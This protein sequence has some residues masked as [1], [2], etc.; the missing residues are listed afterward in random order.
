MLKLVNFAEEFQDWLASNYDVTTL[1]V[2]EN[3][4]LGNILNVYELDKYRQNKIFLTMF[5]EGGSIISSGRRTRQERT[6]RFVFRGNHGQEAI[7]H[8][9]E[10]VAWFKRKKTFETATYR[11]WLNRF[12]RLPTVISAEQSGVSLADLVLTLNVWTRLE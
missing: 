5:E 10:F 12:D 4:T 1:T 8:G 11:A 2:G 6:F 7:N 9:L 3:F